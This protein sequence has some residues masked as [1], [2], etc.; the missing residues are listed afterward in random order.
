MLSEAVQD[1]LKA[2][3]KL[4][5]EGPATTSALAAKLEVT[6]ASATAMVKKLAGLGLVEHERYRGVRLTASGERMALEVVR[7]HRLLELYLMQALGLGW[8]EVHAEAER[9][10]HYLSEELEARIDAALGHPTH[11]PHGDPIPTA[12]LV[13]KPEDRRW[14][15]DVAD[16]GVAVIRRVPDGDPELLRYLASLG[17][18]PEQPIVLV[19]RAPFDG[20][21]T[22]EVDGARHAIGRGLAERIEVGGAAA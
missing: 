8:D 3:W 19:E 12:E 9:L 1:Y 18:V 21:V 6:P 10:E 14:L 13:L 22:V 2:I 20:P 11:D 5:R 15:S 7:H 4:E 17:I 16:G